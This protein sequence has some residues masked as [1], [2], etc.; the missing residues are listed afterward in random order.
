MNDFNEKLS[1]VVSHTAVIIILVRQ[2]MIIVTNQQRE[3]RIDSM[4]G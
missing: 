2:V 4:C 3:T 1:F